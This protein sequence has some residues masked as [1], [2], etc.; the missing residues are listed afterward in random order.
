MK[1]SIIREKSGEGE[2]SGGYHASDSLSLHE[3]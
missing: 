2:K 1:I 3:C